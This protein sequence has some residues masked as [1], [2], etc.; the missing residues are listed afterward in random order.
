MFINYS[1]YL[2]KQEGTNISW[3]VSPILNIRAR[4]SS[5]INDD[6]DS[7]IYEFENDIPGT[8]SN[9]ALSGK[10]TKWYLLIR[11]NIFDNLR[12]W[13]KY[14]TIYYDAVESIGTGD[15][16]SKG[17]TRNDVRLQLSYSY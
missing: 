3:Q 12:F 7:R 13:I 2:T 9:Y 16:Q 17:N 4:F 8:F 14:R 6:Y 11:L 5:F 15:L 1:Q 10:G